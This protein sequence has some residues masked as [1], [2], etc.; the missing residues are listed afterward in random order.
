MYDYKVL[1]P[2][3]V[4]VIV[5]VVVVLAVLRCQLLTCQARTGAFMC[6][7]LMRCPATADRRLINARWTTELYTALCSSRRRDEVTG[8]SK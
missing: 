3:A 5:V 4:V 7:S 8:A 1:I 6:D 2:A